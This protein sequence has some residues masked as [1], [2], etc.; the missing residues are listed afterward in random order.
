MERGA[1]LALYYKVSITIEPPDTPITCLHMGGASIPDRQ[2][3]SA[4]DLTC[5]GDLT[6]EQCL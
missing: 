4:S 5:G 2:S 6:D 3:L 1:V